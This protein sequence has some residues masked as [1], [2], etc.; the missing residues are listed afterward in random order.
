MNL[1]LTMAGQ[2][3]RFI[4]EGY[5][6]PK[7]LLPWKDKTILSE[8]LKEMSPHFDNVYLVVHKKDNNFF[9][10]IKSSMVTYGIPLDNLII[11][12]SSESQ[13]ETVL[14]SLNIVKTLNGSIIIH[15]IDTILYN[16]DYKK[17]KSHLK[18]CDGFVDIFSSSNPNY[19][20]VINNNNKI[21]EISEKILISE[22]ATSG[23]YGF[24]NKDTYFEYYN[25][26][27]ISKIYEKMIKNG[28][29]ILC[30]EIHSENNTLVLGTPNE[31]LNLSKTINL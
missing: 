8:I 30:G 14:K 10:H 6:V 9:S 21:I 19:S 27:Y 28:L 3:S 11:L 4:N 25:N 5:K 12:D 18:N 15:N 22:Y 26:G 20:Y 23:L 17:I 1:I 29:D 24:K 13:S 16:R 2:Y 31:Y 7:F